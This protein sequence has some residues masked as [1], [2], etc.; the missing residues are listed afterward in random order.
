MEHAEAIARLSKDGMSQAQIAKAIPGLSTMMVSLRLKLASASEEEKQLIKEG[1]I[2]PT[3]AT[4]LIS[5]ESDPEKR[6][7]M[8]NEAAEGEDGKLKIKAIGDDQV[9]TETGEVLNEEDK[10]NSLRDGDLTGASSS[11]PI[12]PKD[13]PSLK[14]TSPKAST[15]SGDPAQKAKDQIDSSDDRIISGKA[16]AFDLV[17]KVMGIVKQFDLETEGEQKNNPKL[18]TLIFEADKVLYDLKAILKK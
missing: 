17:I 13:D 5:E 18:T 4:K 3:A 12:D 6:I 7:A 2:S 9:D 14:G 16:T 11:E 1:K 8:I 15:P 10:D